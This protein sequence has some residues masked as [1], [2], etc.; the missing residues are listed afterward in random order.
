MGA[1]HQ[2]GHRTRNLAVDPVINA[3]Y[4]GA[5]M[6]PVNEKPEEVRALCAAL[7]T[8]ERVF[9]PQL[10][11]PESDRGQLPDW[12]Y[13][14]DAKDLATDNFSLDRWVRTVKT[15]TEECI[16]LGHD[17]ICSPVAASD[18][19]DDDL[20]YAVQIGDALD[21][22][23]AGSKL[24]GLQTAFVRPSTLS[25]DG[26]PETV[27]SILTNGR[28]KRIYFVPQWSSKADQLDDAREM[29]GFIKTLAYVSAEVKTLVG[30]SGPEM[31]LWKSAGAESVAT[32]K[33]VNQQRWSIDRWGPK[34]AGGSGN[35]SYY[36]EE[37]LLTWLRT[38]DIIELDRLKYHLGLAADPMLPVIRAYVEALRKDPR[39]PV[40]LMRNGKPVLDEHGKPRKETVGAPSWTKQG[41][42]QWLW[43]FAYTERRLTNDAITA[44]S[45]VDTAIVNWARL[46]AKGFRAVDAG[47]DGSWLPSWLDAL[48]VIGA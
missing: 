16:P 5:I 30:F 21:E 27:A 31:I 43:W 9:D 46:N 22:R 34:K 40:P 2:M 48:D 41:W 38:E 10:Y 25:G 17:A 4:A 18:A 14:A 39:R 3:M 29:S 35:T 42:L 13:F 36:F 7:G 24:H 37:S 11:N 47:N 45:L 26:R 33:Y 23:L 6:S 15:I 32:G 44:R 19:T 28:L 8:L 1:Y 20:G 12:G